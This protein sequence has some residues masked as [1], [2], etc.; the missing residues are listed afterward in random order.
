LEGDCSEKKIINQ[1]SVLNG[2]EPN[3]TNKNLTVN[4]LRDSGCNVYVNFKHSDKIVDS[5]TAVKTTTALHY[6]YD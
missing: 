5:V 6:T 4:L 1:N 3:L 2:K